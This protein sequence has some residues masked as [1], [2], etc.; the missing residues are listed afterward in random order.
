MNKI[1]SIFGWLLLAI[2]SLAL[3]TYTVLEIGGI[4]LLPV[5]IFWVLAGSLLALRLTGADRLLREREESEPT[6]APEPTVCT[7]EAPSQQIEL[8]FSSLKAGHIQP[9]YS[10][11]PQKAP[12]SLFGRA[13]MLNRPADLQAVKLG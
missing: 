10:Q 1:A 7:V 6:D 8:A 9:T 12:E 2:F 13:R 11:R 4:A 5:V 3:G